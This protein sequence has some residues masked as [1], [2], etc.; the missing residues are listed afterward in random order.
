MR[1]AVDQ[2]EFVL[3]YQPKVEI[4]TRKITGAEALLRWRHPEK[5]ILAGQVHPHRRGDRAHRRDRPV[6]PED[7]VRAGRRLASAGLAAPVGLGQR[8]R[9]AVQERHHLARGARCRRAQPDSATAAGAGAH[10]EHADGR[11]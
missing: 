2:G 6:G 5:G 8:G 4:A 9:A 3:F 11:R 7:G 1:K 10:R